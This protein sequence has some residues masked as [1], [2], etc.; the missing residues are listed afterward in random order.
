M[1]YLLDIS[2]PSSCYLLAISLLSLCSLSISVSCYFSVAKATVEL[3]M[4]VYQSVCYQNSSASQKTLISLRISAIKPFCYHAPPQPLRTITIGHHAHQPS[5]PLPISHYAY[6]HSCLSAIMPIS[7]H[8]YQPSCLS[9][10]MPVR[11]PRFKN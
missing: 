1:C 4:S 10:I 8:A 11:I 5:T 3:Q 6:Q 2:L 7:I 9:T